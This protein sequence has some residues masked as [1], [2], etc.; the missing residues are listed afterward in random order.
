[1]FIMFSLPLSPGPQ[2]AAKLSIE[3]HHLCVSIIS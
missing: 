3:L 2:S 1:M